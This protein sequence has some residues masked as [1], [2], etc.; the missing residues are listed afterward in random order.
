M[1]YEFIPSLLEHR[2][3]NSFEIWLMLKRIGKPNDPTLKE[4]TKKYFKENITS[5]DFDLEVL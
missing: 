1:K 5:Q 3:L 2:E 4:L